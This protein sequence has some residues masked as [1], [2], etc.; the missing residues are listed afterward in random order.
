V[1]PTFTALQRA[2]SNRDADLIQG[3]VSERFQVT[4]ER[5]FDALD[6]DL[7]GAGAQDSQLTHVA[8]RRPH[9]GV[10]ARAEH[11]YLN[12]VAR[13]WVEDLRTGE[14]IDGDPAAARGFAQ[15]WTFA[16]DPGDGWVLD[17]IEPLAER[18][19]IT[20]TNWDELPAGWYSRPDRP[21]AFVEWDGRTWRARPAK[22]RTTPRPRR[23]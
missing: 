10:T 6:A 13:I 4:A 11:V 19:A 20:T 9:G 8:V 3:L 7:L 14:V 16:F 17:Q 22:S 18:S 1:G 5:A 12:Y 15:H 21:A 23:G 2:W